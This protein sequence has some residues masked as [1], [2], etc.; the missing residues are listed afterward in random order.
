MADDSRKRRHAGVL[1]G[2]V[3]RVEGCLN[4][5][6]VFLIGDAEPT[7]VGGQHADASLLIGD[8]RADGGGEVEFGL[9]VGVFFAEEGDELIFEQRK[10]GGGEGPAVHG[11]DGVGGENDRGAVGPRDAG[12]TGRVGLEGGL[13]LDAGEPAGGVNLTDAAGD[14]A[15]L[16]ECVSETEADHREFGY[17]WVGD[18]EE[19]GEA[20]EGVSAVE[21]VGV[22]DGEGAVHDATGAPDGVAGAPGFHAVRR[23]SEAGWEVVGLLKGVA[24]FEAGVGGVARADAGAEG[25]LEVTADDEDDLGKAGLAGVVNG[26]VEDGLAAGAERVHLLEAAVAAAQAGGEDDESGGHR[27]KAEL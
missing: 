19:L 13:L 11:D 9:E 18:I 14:G 10:E 6:F 5:G 21:I 1:A 23:R 15:V 3:K 17:A 4:A 12:A 20:A 27:M 24:D 8:E 7:G 22:D 25:F 16:G 2:F 26:V